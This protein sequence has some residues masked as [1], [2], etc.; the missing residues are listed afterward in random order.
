[1]N[2]TQQSILERYSCRDFSDKPVSEEDIKAI[3][4]AALAS[5]SAMNLMPWHLVV[6]TDKSLIDELDRE[7]IRILS[8]S[9]DKT[10]YNR[11]MERGGRLFYNAPCMII[12]GSDG[13][14][15]APLDCGILTENIAL[16][17]HALGLGNVIC[18]MAGIPLRG[19]RAD[20][21]KK[22]IALPDTHEYIMSVLIG[23][24]KSKKAPHELD[25]SKVS[26]VK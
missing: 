6:V 21:F 26:Y 4:E 19:G 22:R 25:F 9:E 12:I 24:A 15:H 3:V 14:D 11:I 16:S 1:M 13:S 23:E 8:E 18:G 2:Q 5:P 17:A 20:E 10:G 7:G